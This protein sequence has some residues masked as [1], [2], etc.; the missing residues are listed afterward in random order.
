MSF[1]DFTAGEVLTAAQMDTTF[2]QTVMRFADASARDTALTTVLAEGMLCYLDDS[3]EIQKYNGASWAS[4]SNPGDI[5]AVTAGTALTG[6]GASGDVTLNVDL[7]AVTIPASQIS[8]LTATAAELNILDG[9]TATATELNYVDGVTSAIQTQ[10]DA[11]Q[12]ELTGLTATVTE[13][14]YTDG[15]TSAIQD[16]LDSPVATFITDA[17]TARTLT[18]ADAG[19]TIRFTSGS[20]TVVTVNASTDLPVGTRVDIIADGVGALTVTASGA[21]VAAAETSTTS[22]SFTIGLQYSAA[23]LLCVAT[24]EYR[25]VGNVAVV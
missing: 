8:D 7:T 14:N 19:K 17:T 1:I 23:T 16:Q 25:L 10:I 20:A 12:D 15:V 5:T 22:G 21:T 3:D 6:G 13:L 4:I 2:R 24:D 18:A 11:K 9:V